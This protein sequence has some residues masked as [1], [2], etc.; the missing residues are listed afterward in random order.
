MRH[1]SLAAVSLLILA[2]AAPAQSPGAGVLVGTVRTSDGQPVP[3]VVL[4]LRGPGGDTTVVTGAEGRYRAEALAP[5]R[6]RLTLRAP[7]FRLAS[8]QEVEVGD[9]QTPL[10]VT[11]EPAPVR[12]HVVVAA[13]R[14]EA[15]AS[16]V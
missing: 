4:V 7:G 9:T 12:E 2:P 3:Q 14:D 15:A 11:L 5:G 16:T 8:T 10:E 1:F 13:T 6:Y